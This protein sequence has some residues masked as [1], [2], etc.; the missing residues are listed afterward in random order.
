MEVSS[1][2][3]AGIVVLEVVAC[4]IFATALCF[5]YPKRRELNAHVWLVTPATACLLL[6]LI[7]KTSRYQVVPCGSKTVSVCSLCR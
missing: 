5:L 6:L 2:A 7:I 1:C 3:F 4:V